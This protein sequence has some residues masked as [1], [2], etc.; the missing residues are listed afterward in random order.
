M[1]SALSMAIREVA[2]EVLRDGR[3]TTN[4]VMQ[5]AEARGIGCSRATVRKAMVSMEE[6]GMVRRCGTTVTHCEVIWEAVQ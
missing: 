3:T 4:R 1:T 5:T 6:D 2:A